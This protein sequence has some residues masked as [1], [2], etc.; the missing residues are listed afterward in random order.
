MLIK[1]CKTCNSEFQKPYTL[2]KVNWMSTLYCSKLCVDKCLII[3][4]KR[5][6]SQKGKVV[7]EETRLRMKHPHKKYIKTREHID[8]IVQS[9]RKGDNYF[10]SEETRIKMSR[11][12]LQNPNIKSWLEKI[13]PVMLKE[14]NP[15]WKGGIMYEP[16]SS[17]WT[18]S[19]K[20][21]IRQRDNYS[22]KKCDIKQTN[23]TFPVHHVD[24]NKKN[25]NPVNL[26][27]LCN[28]CHGKTG[29][30]RKVWI[31]YFNNI[32]T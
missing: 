22:C 2:S 4:K 3:R 7:S 13:R 25:C 8:K 9:R 29:T 17:D 5:S 1:I 14:N 6:E 31:S 24:Y 16:Y 21:S 28:S 30:D 19:L 18:E 32:L 11:V 12:K 20:E 15:N 26:V 27:T 10:T 23:K